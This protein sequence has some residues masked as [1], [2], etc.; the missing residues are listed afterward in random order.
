MASTV[1]RRGASG[2]PD[3]APGS[4]A[5][6]LRRWGT[7]LA[8]ALVFLS[9]RQISLLVLTWMSAATGI[10]T[11]SAL[12]SW[13]GS[14]FLALATGG[15]DDVPARLTDAFGVRTAQTPLAFFPGYPALVAALSWLPGVGVVA[16]AFAVTTCAGVVAS[17]GL[18][19]LAELVPAGS[20]QAGLVLVALFAATP[21]SI[22]LSMTYAESLFCALAVWCLVGL[23]RRQWL[24]AGACCAAAG[25]VRPTAA[26]LVVA[27]WL[28]AGVAVLQGRG[29]W[30]PGMA[31]LIAPSG[32]AG[33]LT[34]VAGRT[35]RWDGWFALQQQGWN[36]GF[37]GGSATLRFTTDVLTS[38]PS[39]LEV[40]TVWL[41]AGALLLLVLCLRDWSRSSAWP[42]L[43]YVAAVLAMNLGSSGLMN[44]K[45]RLLLPAFVLLVPVAI[46]LARRSTTVVVLTLIGL[47]AFGAWFGSYLITVWPYAI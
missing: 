13:D 15:Y 44:S 32:L 4:R 16:A 29:S 3:P 21:M 19:R 40:T 1:L 34:F 12:T 2:Q 8:P 18:V 10:D 5:G 28:A 22:V 31:A 38:A 11:G 27:V 37:D 9:I 42:L 36:S 14:W 7:W 33:Y 39:L 35:G 47:V 25:M 45:A 6:W 41:L 20:R 17:Y 46:G 30:R 43:S 26:A 24:L 23:L